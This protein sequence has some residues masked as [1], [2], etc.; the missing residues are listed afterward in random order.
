VLLFESADMDVRFWIIKQRRLEAPA[1][2]L[3]SAIK[4]DRKN[5]TELSRHPSVEIFS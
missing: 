2:S 1:R 5:F 3:N 4:D